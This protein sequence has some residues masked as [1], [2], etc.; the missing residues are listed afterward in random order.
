MTPDDSLRI[1]R[2]LDDEFGEILTAQGESAGLS[3]FKQSTL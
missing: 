3:L 2:Q 1:R